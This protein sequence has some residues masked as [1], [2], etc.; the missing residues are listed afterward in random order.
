VLKNRLN[1]L[2]TDHDRAKAAPEQ[3]KEHAGSNL[4]IDLALIERIGQTMRENFR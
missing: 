4:Q 1:A 2:K 3:T